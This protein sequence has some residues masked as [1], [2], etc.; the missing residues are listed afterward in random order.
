MRLIYL[1]SVLFAAPA[2][3]AQSH[4]DF[5]VPLERE[6]NPILS[7]NF[8]SSDRVGSARIL[9][10]SFDGLNLD[11]EL[12]SDE[13][14]FLNIDIGSTN[15]FA[16]VIEP[17]RTVQGLMIAPVHTPAS[18][19]NF[20]GP[21]GILRF[22]GPNATTTF[23]TG[24]SG[25]K[26]L[27][28]QTGLF[29]LGQPSSFFNGG[30]QRIFPRSEGVLF[31]ICEPPLTVQMC[32]AFD[33]AESADFSTFVGLRQFG[34]NLE[35]WRFNLTG[36]RQQLLWTLPNVNI[37]SAQLSRSSQGHLSAQLQLAN[38]LNQRVLLNFASE[39]DAE[40]VIESGAVP[41]SGQTRWLPMQDRSWLNH[42]SL[43]NNSVQATFVSRWRLNLVT[44]NG[45]LTVPAQNVYQYPYS[46]ATWRLA[47]SPD[48]SIILINNQSA[49]PFGVG[50]DYVWLNPLGQ[51]V[52]VGTNLNYARFLTDGS[53]LLLEHG[54]AEGQLTLLQRWYN[55]TGTPISP[56]KPLS[57]VSVASENPRVVLDQNRDLILSETVRDQDGMRA[58]QLSRV[59]VTSSAPVVRRIKQL[60]SS[61]NLR[62]T[63]NGRYGFWF[64]QQLIPSGPGLRIIAI[65][66][67]RVSDETEA[68][69][70][71]GC[72]FRNLGA[73]P[74][75]GFVVAKTDGVGSQTMVFDS[76]YTLRAVQNGQFERFIA[77]PG[78]PGGALVQLQIDNNNYALH[79]DYSLRLRYAI[80][81]NVIA[82]NLHA[83]GTATLQ[84]KSGV[85]ARYSN[86]GVSLFGVVG[87]S[88]QVDPVSGACFEAFYQTTAAGS[89]CNIRYSKLDGSSVLGQQCDNEFASASIHV[90]SERSAIFIGNSRV[91]D[92]RL[93]ADGQLGMVI[94]A[95]PELAG[96]TSRVVLP[97]LD[98]QAGVDAPKRIFWTAFFDNRFT[99]P[100]ERRSRLYGA[101]LKVSLPEA[102]LVRDGFELR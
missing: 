54:R 55:A 39:Q 25:Q 16:G 12:G 4:V 28:L 77:L 10:L 11:Y 15:S 19:G 76:S 67:S 56:I 87:C 6:Q 75:G 38:L 90:L 36:E 14:P 63:D 91:F 72:S 33:Y 13:R 20:V 41:H 79:A 45:V 88:G 83:D 96:V 52:R 100:G 94:Q 49:S 43:S 81:E 86:S 27:H 29:G 17:V 70:C 44:D 30:F 5:S 58:T 74:G 1:A 3:Q 66:T 24:F 46:A 2:L 84:D 47:H 48:G 69:R 40:R 95:L 32:R 34:P 65:N 82:V 59:D 102:E 31:N 35:L 98:S 8:A 97:E 9:A 62:A 78:K 26:L 23:L 68:L 99:F 18:N 37:S 89:I 42:N 7:A 61:S 80:P 53:V 21:N 57:K 92:V 22:L 73:L 93:K 64:A 51:L 60:P 85:S 50:R 71:D 101:T